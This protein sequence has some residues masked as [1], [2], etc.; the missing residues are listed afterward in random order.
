MYIYCDRF[1]TKLCK[2]SLLYNK[3]ARTSKWL[4][5]ILRPAGLFTTDVRLQ[6]CLIDQLQTDLIQCWIKL[7]DSFIQ[8]QWTA[9]SS[10]RTTNATQYAWL[11]SFTKLFSFKP[12]SS[13]PCCG[14]VNVKYASRHTLYYFQIS[15][16][17]LSFW[18]SEYQICSNYELAW[19]D[20]E[21]AHAILTP[22]KV[23]SISLQEK[24]EFSENFIACISQLWAAVPVN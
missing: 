19:I 23:L 3:T 13:N 22:F 17:T 6:W 21:C 12:A 24:S 2:K 5:E 4:F 9:I 10:Q 20:A 7:I 11:K 1:Y 16:C 14:C 15:N 18:I 8:S